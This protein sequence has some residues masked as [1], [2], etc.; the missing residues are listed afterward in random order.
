MSSQFIR[1]HAWLSLLGAFIFMHGFSEY[2]PEAG[3]HAANAAFQWSVTN[4]HVY[5]GDLIS[6]PTTYLWI[7]ENCEKVR[8]LLVMGQNVPEQMLSSH[9]LIRK[10]C[11]EESLGIVYSCPSWLRFPKPNDPKEHS[12]FFKEI[13]SSLAEVSGYR[14]VASVPWLPIGES[15]HLILV[16]NLIEGAPERC[17]AGIFVKNPHVAPKNRTVP[18]LTIFGTAQEW[19]QDKTDIRS[20]WNK[21]EPVK[22]LFK[23]RAD[24]PDWAL[25]LVVDGHSGHFECS[26]KIVA[27]IARYIRSATKARL[28][29]ESLKRISMDNGWI[30]DLALPGHQALP[31]KRF[32]DASPDEQHLPW[33]FDLDAAL[34]AQ[35]T[36]RINWEAQTQMVGFAGEDGEILPFSFR[37][38]PWDLPVH[39]E[40]DGITFSFKAQQLDKL[41]TH[42][43]GADSVLA[44]TEN[45][46]V[47]EWMCGPFIPLGAGRFQLAMDRTFPIANYVCIRTKGNS[48]V[49]EIVTPGGFNIEAR[50]EGLDQ[51]IDFEK[52]SD[53]VAGTSSLDLKAKATSGLPVRFFVKSGPAAVSECRLSFTKIPP[54]SRYPIEVTVCAW[55][56]GRDRGEKIKSAPTASQTFRILSPSLK[57][58]ENSPK[59]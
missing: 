7:P 41:P 14:E 2:S 27:V 57:N 37:G 35:N 36:S 4:R 5:P 8:G 11:E 42:F 46:P 58:K 13:V 24:H 22:G 18:Q 54:G 40:E 31:P 50:K 12:D 15:G 56:W 23:Q 29:G 10:I 59:P 17:I 55:Q 19:D 45:K 21:M 39:Y 6:S 38:V 43:V 16:D 49:R 32:V 51:S 30:A 20:N 26:E 9:P 25:S 44:Q 1:A 3:R 48:N 28:G 52:I 47:I 33:F 53:V 34:E